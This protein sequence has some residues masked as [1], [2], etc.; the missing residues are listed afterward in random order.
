M[1]G[2][3]RV[4]SILVCACLCSCAALCRRPP[5]PP[6]FFFQVKPAW[7]V[8]ETKHVNP[9]SIHLIGVLRFLKIN[10]GLTTHHRGRRVCDVKPLDDVMLRAKSIRTMPAVW[11][12]CLLCGLLCCLRVLCGLVRWFYAVMFA[13]LFQVLKWVSGCVV[14]EGVRVVHVIICK[15]VVQRGVAPQLPFFFVPQHRC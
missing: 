10:P 15:C 14:L 5:P 6:S 12:S 3:C 11:S 8:S 13:L 1:R 7:S 4:G 2:L 9:K